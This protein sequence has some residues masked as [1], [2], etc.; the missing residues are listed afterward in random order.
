[1]NKQSPTFSHDLARATLT[2][3]FIGGLIIATLW[4][5]LPFLSAFIWATTI[6]ISTWPVLLSIQGKLQGRRGLAT[7]TL[8]F[9][10]LLT[11]IVP[12]G[13]SVV[14]LVQNMDHIVSWVQ[15]V[16]QLALPPPP[17]WLPHIPLFGPKLSAAWLRLAS[18][19]LGSLP[20]EMQ[21]QVS[22]FVHWFFGQIGG[23]A[24][25]VLQF[26]LTVIIAAIL[27]SNG[28][29][30]A[31]GVQGFAYRLGGES[32]VKVLGIAAHSVR[33]VAMGV[34]L[35]AI[36]QAV[37]TGIGLLM[38]AIPAAVVLTAIVFILCLA[39]LGPVLVM[40]PVIAWKFYSGDAFW[41]TVL[42][43]VTLVAQTIDNVL[44]PILIRKG[45]N[46]PL[47]LIFAGV[48]GGLIALGIVG[49][50]IGPVILA[51]S[52]TL[53]QDWVE[54]KSGVPEELPRRDSVAAT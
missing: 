53:I 10:L 26:L 51:V 35:T 21:P 2:V 23:I 48:I 7:A 46:L 54:N 16:H 49:I 29:T 38:A 19:G 13:I 18:S 40:L 8:T 4:I 3:L 42:L 12:L 9:L 41:G 32:G 6:V 5:V 34:V 14:V 52:Y 47:L 1:M 27:Y 25:M 31:R 22:R 43:V 45:A 24:A 36:V 50:F 15:S 28:E 44:R 20:G 11:L 39:Q 17:D 37:L 33:G 30:A